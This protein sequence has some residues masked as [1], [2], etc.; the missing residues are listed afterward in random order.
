MKEPLRRSIQKS[1]HDNA[2][3]YAGGIDSASKRQF[4]C[5]IYPAAMFQTRAAIVTCVSNPDVRIKLI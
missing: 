5:T 2:L 1:F 3:S 4:P